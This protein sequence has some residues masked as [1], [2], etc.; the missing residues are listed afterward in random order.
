MRT[1]AVEEEYL[2]KVSILVWKHTYVT[3]STT[4]IELINK[5]VDAGLIASQVFRSS[6][7]A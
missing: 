7:D 2:E 1:I 4:Y 5:C 3:R 6:H